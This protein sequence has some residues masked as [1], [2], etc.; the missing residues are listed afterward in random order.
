MAI[1]FSLAQAQ[2]GLWAAGPE[3]LFKG[4]GDGQPIPQPQTE[5]TCCAAIGERIVVGGSP[6]G[7]AFTFDQG[8]NWQAAW[9]DNVRARVL[10]LA[11]DPEVN[12]TGV[13]LAGAEGAGVLRSTDRGRMWT[14]CNFGLQHYTILALGWAP[15]APVQAWPQWQIVLAATE[16]GLYRSPNGGLGWKRCTGAEGLFQTLAIARDFHASG[17]V[18]AGTENEGLWRSTDGGHHFEQVDQ[19][20]EQINALTALKD[21]WLLSDQD[22]LWHSTD[23]IK[24]RRVPKSKPALVLLATERSIWAGG[25]DGVKKISLSPSH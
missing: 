3:G 1:I 25:E 9:M 8:K 14:P 15:P 5:L 4:K 22:R 13:I 19:A 12:A 16:D 20:P 2:D 21:G 7:V 18:L 10:C 24:W 17:L 6:Y 11:P 23:G